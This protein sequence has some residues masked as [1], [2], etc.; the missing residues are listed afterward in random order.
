[1]KYLLTYYKCQPW[2]E[3]A[4]ARARA[5]AALPLRGFGEKMSTCVAEK[6]AHHVC[7]YCEPDKLP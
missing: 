4:C 3:H 7:S 5:V 1:V 2:I 6:R